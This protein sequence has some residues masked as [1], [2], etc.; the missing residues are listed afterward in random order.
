[1]CIEN[2]VF[3]TVTLTGFGLLFTELALPILMP[4]WMDMHEA[5]SE[6]HSI[7][8]HSGSGLDVSDVGTTL[9]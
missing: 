8:C 3:G 4:Q 9:F 6:T 7:V 2:V 5:A 1:M